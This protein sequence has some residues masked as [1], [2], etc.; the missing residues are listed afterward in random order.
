MSTTGTTI[1]QGS[2]GQR[3]DNKKW[4]ELGV[5]KELADLAGWS[6]SGGHDVTSQSQERRRRRCWEVR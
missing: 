3:S 5:D 1:C 4:R 6:E 2:Q